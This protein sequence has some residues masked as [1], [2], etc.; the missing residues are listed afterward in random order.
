MSDIRL[1]FNLDSTY[2]CISS[3]EPDNEAVPLAL[4]IAWQLEGTPVAEADFCFVLDKSSSMRESHNGQQGAGSRWEAIQRAMA[5]IV[6]RLRP[7]DRVGVVTFNDVAMAVT[8]QLVAPGELTRVLAGLGSPSGGTHIGNGVAVARSLMAQ[9]RRPG[10][11]TTLLLLTDGNTSAEDVGIREVAAAADQGF[12]Y[13]GMGFGTDWNTNYLRR[14]AGQLMNLAPVFI[15]DDATAIDVFGR[16]LGQQQ[17]TVLPSVRL[18][19]ILNTRDISWKSVRSQ[20]P[21][22]TGHQEIRLSRDEPLDAAP[23]M[24]F[25]THIGNVEAGQPYAYVLEARPMHK[26]QPGRY[27]VARFWLEAATGPSVARISH[28]CSHH[29]EVI[30]GPPQFHAATPHNPRPGPFDMWRESKLPDHMDAL[31]K[32]RQRGDRVEVLRAWP[33]LIK[34]MKDLRNREAS[35]EEQRF[36]AWQRNTPFSAAEQKRAEER[37][38]TISGGASEEARQRILGRGPIGQIRRT[39][40]RV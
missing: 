28:E 24:A 31:H 1:K 20:D 5:A 15:A 32:L 33:V 16:V 34:L 19:G 11:P 2:D 30:S 8:P 38:G 17:R 27:P 10:L 7:R 12:G 4:A 3:R 23:G 21:H 29:L 9:H 25:T 26:L 36:E 37:T 35:A 40:C 14:L 22:K 39:L 13:L 6:P 18:R